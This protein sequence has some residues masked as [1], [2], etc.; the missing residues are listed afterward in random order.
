MKSITIVF[1]FLLSCHLTTAQTFNHEGTTASGAKMLLGKINQEALL[2]E[3]F[4]EWFQ[5]N[6]DE[7]TPQQAIIE[8]LR[9]PLASYTITAFMGTWCGDSKRQTPRFYKILEAANFPLNRFTLVG[10]DRQR[11]AYKKSPGGEQEGLN[12]HR[13]PTFIFYK[14]GKEINRIVESP[15]A[16]LEED[17][18]QIMQGTYTSKYHAVTV[19]S[20]FLSDNGVTKLKKKEKSL[21]K[22]LQEDIQSYGELRTY[23]SILSLDDQLEEA[24]AV[25]KL[26]VRLF[27]DEARAH[28]GLA[29]K[30]EAQGSLD[31]AIESY[32]KAAQLDPENDELQSKIA[33]LNSLKEGQ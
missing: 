23:A 24:I 25:S 21:A 13:V 26:N 33:T 3:P 4:K 32:R 12:I 7:Y 11:D 5:A 29:S 30:W 20:N 28:S 6:K 16:S 27:P 31:K 9:S 10:V 18:L 22:V 2:Q 17:M 1:L 19:T 8:Q 15:V 14:N